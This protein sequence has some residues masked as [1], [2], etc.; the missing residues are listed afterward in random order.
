MIVVVSPLE[1]SLCT[2]S[3]IILIGIYVT[4]ITSGEWGHL[5]VVFSSEKV[6]GEGEHCCKNLFTSYCDPTERFMIYGLDADLIMLCLATGLDNIYVY[7]D[8][9]YNPD[10]RFVIDIG[11]FGKKLQTD[12]K[13]KSAIVD[14]VFL[15]F[16][17]GNDFPSTN[18]RS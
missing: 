18:S 4:K 5:D 10:E 9:I 12:M 13:T 14:F 11:K 7:R 1:Q 3:T 2:T 8:N 15:C 6:P 17:V 16:M